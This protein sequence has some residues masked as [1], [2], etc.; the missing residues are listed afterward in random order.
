MTAGDDRPAHRQF[1]DV[2][3]VD[4]WSE[5]QLAMADLGPAAPYWRVQ[6]IEGTLAPS[7][8]WERDWR[9]RFRLIQYKY[10]HW[11]ELR[12][13]EAANGLTLADV[14]ELCDEL[15]FEVEELAD[16]ARVLGYRLLR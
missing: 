2:A 12:P 4:T 16:R 10:I 9:H 8:G 1:L 7:S 14:V 5:L 3:T 15:G 11:C 13:R 6:D